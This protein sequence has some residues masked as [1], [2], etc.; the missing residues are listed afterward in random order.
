MSTPARG[1]HSMPGG[2]TASC[3]ATTPSRSIS[4]STALRGRGGAAGGRGGRGR[5]V[6]GGGGGGGGGGA[7]LG[8]G[9]GGGGGVRRHA[10]ALPPPR[11]DRTRLLEALPAN[12]SPIFCIAPDPGGRLQTLVQEAVR[13]GGAGPPAALREEAGR[14]RA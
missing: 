13:A 4:W 11:A 1:A 12:L 2:R 10:P 14:G 9:G 7:P 6:W 5:P 8:G 3:G